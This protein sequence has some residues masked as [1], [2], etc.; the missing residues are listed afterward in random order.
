VEFEPEELEDAL[1][2][3]CMY[4]ADVEQ[5]G[6]DDDARWV[7]TKIGDVIAEDGEER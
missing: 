3:R 5:R 1:D 2:R 4:E 7:V 6:Q